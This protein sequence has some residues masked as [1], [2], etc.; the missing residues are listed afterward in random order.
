MCLPSSELATALTNFRLSPA[1]CQPFR[2]QVMKRRSSAALPSSVTT[3]A[4]SIGARR[5][6]VMASSRI[7]TRQ[8]LQ[9]HVA[10][11]RNRPI[12]RRRVSSSALSAAR[13][14]IG[15]TRPPGGRGEAS[16]H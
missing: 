4:A 14:E 13:R 11:K 15:P 2:E 5:L 12:G 8:I 16:R 1:R 6:S 9:L 7:S 10:R 3:A